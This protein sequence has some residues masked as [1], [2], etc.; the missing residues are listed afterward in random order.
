MLGDG[1]LTME[2]YEASWAKDPYDP[3]YSGVERSTLRYMSDGPE[4]DAEFLTIRS[5]KS[6]VSWDDS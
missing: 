2:S 5:P 4:Y 3:N 6:V 1:T